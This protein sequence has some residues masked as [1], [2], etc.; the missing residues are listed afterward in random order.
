MNSCGEGGGEASC[1]AETS[2]L[3]DHVWSAGPV[4]A[5]LVTTPSGV[6]CAGG[7]TVN[8]GSGTGVSTEGGG[9][10]DA[11]LAGRKLTLSSGSLV[12]PAEGTWNRV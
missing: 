12:H 4:A 3:T 10:E 1:G 8:R 6:A 9:S 11:S 2:R 7:G 5:S